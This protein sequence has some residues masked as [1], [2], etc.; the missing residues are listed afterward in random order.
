MK[1][2]V[3]KTVLAALLMVAV[4]FGVLLTN[5]NAGSIYDVETRSFEVSD[6][7]EYSLE[8]ML[9]Y[10]IQDEYL[11]KAE[12]ELIISE[13][14]EIRPFINIVEAEQTHIDMLLPLFE[15]YNIQVPENNADELVVLPESITSALATGVEAEEMNIAMYKTFLNQENLP[16]DVRAVF[17]YLINASENHLNAFSKDRYNYLGSDM[18]QGIKNMFRKGGNASENGRQNKMNQQEFNQSYKTS[19]CIND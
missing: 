8:E 5:V 17:E 19:S 10:A 14:G 1:T 9:V 16:D 4:G 3:G 11:A 13:Y 15:T 18:V 12:Y 2:K 7:V 6:D